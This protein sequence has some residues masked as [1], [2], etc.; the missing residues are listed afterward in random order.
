MTRRLTMLILTGFVL[1]TT[2]H[3]RVRVVT[4]LSDL[5]AIVK[6][7][8]G[9][10]V[11]ATSMAKGYQNAHRID[12][13]PSF[14]LALSRAD[15]FVQ[16]GMDLEIA[17]VP[18]LLDA[19]RN[20]KIQ[21]G[22]A[23]HVDASRGIPVLERPA[24]PTRAE[25]D[26]HVFGNPHYWLDP[27]NGKRMA[28]AICDKLCLMDPAH[29]QAYHRNL[30]EFVDRLDRKIPEWKQ[31]LAPFQ[32]REVVGYHN[33][34]PYLMGFAGLTMRHFLEP[35]PGIPPTPKQVQLIE[36]RVRANGIR[37]VV[38]ATFEP[39]EAARA[40]AKR[41]GAAVVLLCQNVRELP[42]ASDYVALLEYN[43]QQ[44]AQALGGT[45]Q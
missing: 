10:K 6:A 14:I 32:G 26:I 16:V 13:K 34:W 3:A 33:A 21:R 8:G 15:L 45:A 11:D 22:G 7:V 28:Q 39:P 29:E 27:E 1:T 19:S 24:N 12:A 40:L 9:D 38:Q 2:A 25:G 4:T 43:V 41:T 17:W 42:E 31:R 18:P 35:K 5:A 30:R 20:P 36:Q 44:L 37:A 23:G